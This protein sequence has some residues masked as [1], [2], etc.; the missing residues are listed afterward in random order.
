[1][2]R[3]HVMGAINSPWHFCLVMEG[4]LLAPLSRSRY[5]WAPNNYPR[6]CSINRSVACTDVGMIG[7][8]YMS[9]CFT[10]AIISIQ[11]VLSRIIDMYV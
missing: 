4:F 6:A 8:E 5:D 7:S 2:R 9:T 3:E 1:M 11:T 10:D